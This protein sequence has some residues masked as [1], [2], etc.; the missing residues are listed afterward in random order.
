MPERGGFAAGKG[1]RLREG[2][3]ARAKGRGNAT[4]TG[5]GIA[6]VRSAAVASGVPAARRSRSLSFRK[7]KAAGVRRSRRSSRSRPPAPAGGVLRVPASLPR[8]RVAFHAPAA[9]SGVVSPCAASR[10]PS[11][12]PVAP[13]FAL[14]RENAIAFPSPA[15]GT[16]P[17]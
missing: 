3:D 16:I 17:K 13:A 7:E 10:C 12:A 2:A 14:S 1:K 11:R 9:A 15:G 6:P 5:G 8:R 4:I